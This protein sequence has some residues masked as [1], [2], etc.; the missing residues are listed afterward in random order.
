MC[1]VCLATMGLYVTGAV[2]AGAGTTLF[3]HQVIAQATRTDRI[4]HFH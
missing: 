4:D 2:S 3:G 1:P